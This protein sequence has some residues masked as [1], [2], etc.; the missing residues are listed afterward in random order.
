MDSSTVG[1]TENCNFIACCSVVAIW[2]T[3][4]EEFVLTS[5]VFACCRYIGTLLSAKDVQ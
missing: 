1:S 4:T 3:L 2:S 5:I